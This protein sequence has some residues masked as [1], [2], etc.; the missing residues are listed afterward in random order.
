M[1]AA[2]AAKDTA[3]L[4]ESTIHKIKNGSDMV[5]RTNEAFAKV[6]VSTKK[7]SELVDE[8]AAASN[9]QARGIEEI[10]RAVTEMDKVVQQNSA[11][12]EESSSASEEMSAQAW[13]M[14]DY[15]KDLMVLL[16]GKRV[17]DSLAAETLRP[18]STDPVFT[19]VAS[20]PKRD[21]KKLLD[22]IPLGRIGAKGLLSGQAKVLEGA[23]E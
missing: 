19:T 8:I 13:Q 10:N 12:A 14:R 11:N 7:A 20:S 1:R 4:I 2:E 16:S 6:A 9:E 5:S 22:P 3:N 23:E 15:V 18:G 21:T 17:D